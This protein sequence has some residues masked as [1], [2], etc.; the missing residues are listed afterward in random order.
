[1]SMYHFHNII[2]LK[3]CKFNNG[4]LGTTYK[5]EVMK[6]RK[7]KSEKAQQLPLCSLSDHS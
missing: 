7:T 5:V 6:I 1:M 2:K 4:K 3:N